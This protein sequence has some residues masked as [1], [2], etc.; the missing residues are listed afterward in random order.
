M[1]TFPEGFLWGASTAAYQVEGG[2]DNTDWAKAAREGKVPPCGKATDHYN[3]FEADFDIAKSLGHNAHRFS[4]EWARIEPEE[5]KFDEKEIEHYR[6]VLR[7]LRDRGIEPFV[8]LWHFTVPLWFA[9]QG[10]FASP[11]APRY[12]ARYARYV[13]EKLPGVRFFITINEPMI[14]ASDA[15][16][17][18][19]WPPFASNFFAY[20]RVIRNLIKAHRLAYDAIKQASPE[21]SVGI[22]G[23]NMY[24]ESDWK[25]WNRIAVIVMR[26]FWNR[27]F[28]NAIADKQDFIGLNHYF[29][30]QFGKKT[31]FDTTDMGW[32]ISP[33]GLYRTLI[34]L[35]EYAKPVYVSENGIADAKDRKRAD[36]I[37]GYLSA[38]HRA[39]SE[40]VPVKGY[41]HWSLLDNYEWLYGFSMR[42]GLVAVDYET[43]QRTIRPSA[44]VYKQVIERNALER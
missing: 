14:W 6:A 11:E 27:R 29:H 12:F 30:V 21:T 3:R 26:W 33:E 36:Y 32:N 40:G 8:N 37:L 18:G 34:E 31:M 35:K 44:Y 13:C 10:N 43:F 9:E 25:P 7:A 2:I 22:A 24:F 28:L 4:V 16:L 23:N 39:I 42:F 1:K 38:M 17:R 5:G 20:L 15:Y 41:F 19:K